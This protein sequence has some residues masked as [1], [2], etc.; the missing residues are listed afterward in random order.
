MCQNQDLPSRFWAISCWMT[1]MRNCSNFGKIR[2]FRM[3]FEF[4]IKQ[5]S[6]IS[7]EKQLILSGFQWFTTKKCWLPLNFFDTIYFNLFNSCYT[8]NN[9]IF[10][11]NL[12]TKITDNIHMQIQNAIRVQH[13]VIELHNNDIQVYIQ[14]FQKH[15]SSHMSNY[16]WMKRGRL[17]DGWIR[18]S[19][20]RA[21]LGLQFNL[22]N[23]TYAYKQTS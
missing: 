10:T 5:N 19:I 22:L 12:I 17:R 23:K 9:N 4:D 15:N 21:N 7:I 1:R 18:T 20:L 2:I 16:K 11:H 3:V 14:F 8:M 6:V 13:K